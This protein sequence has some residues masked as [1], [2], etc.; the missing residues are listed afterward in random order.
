MNIRTAKIVPD[1]RVYALSNVSKEHGRRRLTE[2]QAQGI[3]QPLRTPTGRTLLSF[4]DAERLAAA[5]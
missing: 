1:L 5:L 4:E 3:V 2:L